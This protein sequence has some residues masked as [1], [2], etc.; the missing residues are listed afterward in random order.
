MVGGQR[1]AY[2]CQIYKGLLCVTVGLTAS[3]RA[4]I[5]WRVLVQSVAT[6]KSRN[7]R[8]RRVIT[9]IKFV[10]LR[11]YEVREREEETSEVSI[12]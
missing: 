7:P 3:A 10:I 2:I 9:W 11:E 12:E 6:L 1:P 4:T 5:S 8:V